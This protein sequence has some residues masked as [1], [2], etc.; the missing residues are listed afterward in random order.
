MK[1]GSVLLGVI[2]SASLLGDTKVAFEH[3]PAAVQAAAKEQAKGASITGASREVEKGQTTYE[4]ETTI[5]GKSRDLSFDGTGKLLEIE[6]EVA[7]ESLPV[8]AKESLQMRAGSA[9]IKKVES[10]TAA[11]AVSYEATVV[12]KNGKKSEIAVNSDG[13]RHRD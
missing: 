7:L 10:V 9:T 5:G 6:E 4:V 12:G 13:T 1:K 3:L 2:A 11:S 8:K